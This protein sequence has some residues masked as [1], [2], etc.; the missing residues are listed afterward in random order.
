MIRPPASR[1]LSESFQKNGV[2]GG[3][4]KQEAQPPLQESAGL[5]DPSS[6]QWPAFKADSL[7]VQ[8]HVP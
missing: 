3:W 7:T 6:H 2:L 4:V 5:S 1:T 8:A